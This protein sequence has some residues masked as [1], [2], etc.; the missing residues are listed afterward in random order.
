MLLDDKIEKIRSDFPYLN[1]KD[2][3]RKIIYLDN[4][5]TSQKPISV[6]KAVEE[7]YKF[8]NANP[9]RGAHYL[10]VKSTD[11]YEG[12]REKVAK[13]IN[14]KQSAEVIFTR[15]TTES[16]NLIAYSYALENLRKGDEI[17]I[18]ILEHH[19]NFVTWQFVAEKTGAI[20]KIA[21]LNEDFC[22]D[23]DD[24]KKK[25]SDKTKIVAFT[26]ASN[27]TSYMS[28]VEEI[29]KLAHEKGAIAIVDAAQLAPHKAVDVQKMDCDFLAISG[30]KML[31]PMGI[32]ILYGKRQILDSM[33]PFMYGGEM[34]E[35]VYESH[36]T[37]AELPSKFEAGTVNVG[38]TVGLGAAIDY[39]NNI[40][41]DNIYKRESELVS[42]LVTEMNKIPYVDIYYPQK[43]KNRGAAVAFNVKEV[44]PHDT[45][46]ILDSY[47]IALRS[48]HHCTMPLHAYLNINAS[49]RAS[50]MFYNTK[51]E[52]DEFLSH[53]ED[54]RRTMGYGLK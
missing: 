40:G 8:Q 34:I 5:A 23:M 19:S 29:V 48:V 9:H 26:G 46:S 38:G 6:I 18:T 14:A 15:N 43:A 20:L 17:L 53:L 42:Y 47:N 50:L 49:C 51:E 24:F 7:Y 31:S 28:D 13:F 39:I 30:H 45:A 27:V 36:S 41:I 54:V 10:T 1:E 21:Y 11:A 4:S 22:L 37:F 33:K 35:Y 52:I 12:A 3:G 32:G 25:L 2:M 44:H 16:L